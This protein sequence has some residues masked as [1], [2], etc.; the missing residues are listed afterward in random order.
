MKK[1]F[2]ALICLLSLVFTFASN[3]IVVYAQESN[4]K[5]EE[6]VTPSTMKN[7]PISALEVADGMAT[8]E[9]ELES[10]GTDVVAELEKQIEYYQELLNSFISQEQAEQIE[11]LI[12]TT[13]ELINEYQEYMNTEQSRGDF[14][15]IYTPAVATVIAY[16]NSQD[17]NLAAELLTHARDN[18]N[19]DSIYTPIN[20]DDVL[21]SSVYTSIREGA[22]L[23][24]TG[25]FASSNNT[26]DQDLYYA[27]HYFYYTKSAS[28]RV[29]VIQD[30]YDYAHS[31]DYGSIGGIA[32]N[33][34][35]AAQEAGVLVPYYSVITNNFDG[36]S[37]NP[38]ETVSISS[39]QRYYEDKV[40]IGKGEYKDYYVTFKSSGTKVFQTFGT[41]DAYLYLYD[42]NG[43]LLT[44]N[45]D[46]G[47]SLNALIR[48]YCSAN[49]QYKIRVKFYSSTQSGETKL[50]ITPSYGA[51][52][53]DSSAL[54]TYEDIYNTSSSNF[55]FN[56]FS[57]KGYVRLFTYTP[58]E[59]AYYTVETE[60]NVDTYVYLIDPRSTYLLSSADYNDDAGEGLNA[61]VNK[62]LAAN[63]PYL[64]VYSRWDLTGTDSNFSLRI[65]KD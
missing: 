2:V 44:S 47:Y 38:T 30:R 59:K 22:T 49:V 21:S 46:G 34:M 63:V 61:S 28:G 23:E 42:S 26:N 54:N 62:E 37:S 27:F 58:S 9:Q 32:V 14:H 18:N 12:S 16:F 45:D 1:T 65:Y 25:E 56:T 8:L 64:I 7:T 31:D 5:V 40:T 4:D 33:V 41:K 17:Y 52:K 43:N 11:N 51:L 15:L 19:L 10:K 55:T 29:V 48:Y 20:S 24:G 57:N 35:Y 13:Q 36:T 53:S 60:G 39:S 50:A 6:V 3:G